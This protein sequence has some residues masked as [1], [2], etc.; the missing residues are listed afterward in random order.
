MI[1]EQHIWERQLVGAD[2]ECHQA[3]HNHRRDNDEASVFLY[4]P[5]QVAAFFAGAFFAG[6]FLAGAF[7]AGAF[8]AGAFFAG[9][10]SVG[11]STDLWLEGH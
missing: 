5:G 7:L 3:R 9:V 10:F 8:L 1:P 4:S 2:T 11:R 6:A